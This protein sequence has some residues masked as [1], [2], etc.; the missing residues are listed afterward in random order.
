MPLASWFPII[1]GDSDTNTLS[2]NVHDAKYVKDVFGNKRELNRVS[3]GTN[4]KDSIYVEHRQ[5]CT[6]DNGDNISV[7]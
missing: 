5:L 6:R 2:I 4:E 7:N 1:Y 3:G